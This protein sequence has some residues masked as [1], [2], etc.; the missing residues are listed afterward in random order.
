MGQKSSQLVRPVPQ[1]AGFDDVPN[2]KRP[3]PVAA[4]YDPSQGAESGIVLVG[5]ERMDNYSPDAGKPVYQ[6]FDVNVRR[7]APTLA[8]GVEL[9]VVSIPFFSKRSM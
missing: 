3:R 7:N 5:K 4:Y 8:L 1:V 6:N 2:N 9:P